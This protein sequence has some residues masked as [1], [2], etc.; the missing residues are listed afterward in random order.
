MYKKKL[1]STAVATAIFFGFFGASSAIYAESKVEQELSEYLTSLGVQDRLTWERGEGDSLSNATIYGV[2]YINKKGTEEEETVLVKKLSFEDY[3]VTDD[4]ISVDVRYDGIT[5]EDGVHM[6]LSEKLRQKLS[7]KELGYQQLDDIQVKVKYAKDKVNDV[8]EGEFKMEQNELLD[9]VLNFKTEG[10]DMLIEQ[11]VGA[12]VAT[13]DP[14]LILVSAMTPKIH[15]FNLSLKDDGYNKRVLEHNPEHRASVEQKY[16]DC[17]DGLGEYTIKELED[18]CVVVRDYLLDKEDKLRIGINPEK[19]FSI[20]EYMPMFMLL[21]SS[22]PD[23]I[24]QL[25]EKIIKEINLTVSN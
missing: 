2:S 16:E 6:L 18:S 12:D 22:G 20:G 11:L 5:D 4:G 8:L 15:H 1:L 23:A 10:L 13:L 3:T 17:V 24:T 14:N 9:V 19:P 25:V 21:G 7:L